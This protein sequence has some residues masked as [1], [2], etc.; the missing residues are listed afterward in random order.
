MKSL[1]IQRVITLASLVVLFAACKS[2]VDDKT[3]ATVSEP[4]P[5]ATTTAA[6]APGTEVAAIAATSKIEFVG[7]KVTRDHKGGFKEFSG[8]VMWVDGKPSSLSFDIDMNSIFT[9]TEK[10][11]GHL[12]TPDFFDVATYPKATFRSTSITEAAAGNTEGATHTISGTL[13]MHGVE[14]AIS[15][16]V[17]VT[18]DASGVGAMAEFTINRHDWGV[19]YKGASDDLI[20]DDV[21][22]R[23]D[24]KF[25]P[26]PAPPVPPA[27]PAVQG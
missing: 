10:L 11:T 5:A 17:K 24:M 13:T 26:A 16:P 21:L 6:T 14:K 1:S 25:P 8:S 12:K 20:K 2:E 27:A 23:L 15:F 7:A 4:A 9:D 22:I 19:S 18:S 3:A